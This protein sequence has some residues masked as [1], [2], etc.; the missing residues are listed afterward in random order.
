MCMYTYKQLF[1]S[2][3]NLRAL[4]TVYTFWK[5]INTGIYTASAGGG[6]NT[7]FTLVCIIQDL[8]RIFDATA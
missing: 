6:Q 1:I 2:L 8:V 4:F 5:C 7:E 3:K